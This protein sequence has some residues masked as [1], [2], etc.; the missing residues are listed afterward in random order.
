[1]HGE[2]A[3]KLTLG[4]VYRGVVTSREEDGT[5][6][7]SI[8]SPAQEVRGVLLAVPV[9][10]GL[11]GFNVKCRLTKDTEVELA[12]GEPSFIHSV[13]PRNSSDWVNARNRSLIWGEPSDPKSK[14]K[15]NFSEVTDDLVE[16]EIE[17]SNLFGV[18]LSLLTTLSRMSSGDRAAVECHLIND[19]VR[20]ISAQYRHISGIGDD[21]IFDRGRPTMERRWSSYRHELMNALKDK[22]PLAEL[23]GD[24]VARNTVENERVTALGRHRFIELVGFAGDFIHSFV[25]DP[26]DAAVKLAGAVTQDGAGKSWIH[27]NSD[28]SLIFQSVADIRFERVCRIPVVQRIASHE[29]PEVT[30]KTKYDALNKEYL[31]L[32]KFGRLE[33]KNAFLMAYHIR[34]YARWLSRYHAF[35][36]TLQLDKEY[37]IKSEA[38]SAKPSWTNA[39]QD[40]DDKNGKDIYF[41]AYACFCI[42]R[43]G[44]IVLHD[45]Y[46]SSIVA[47]HGNVQISASRNIDLEAAG[48]VRIVAG[49]NLYLRAR[50]NIEIITHAGGI[51]LY[52]YAWLKAL[53]AKGSL[54]LRSSAR[55]DE[56]PPDPLIQGGPKPEIAGD[57]SGRGKAVLIESTDGELMLRSSS[58]MTIQSDGSSEEIK[59]ALV[60][61]SNSDLILRGKRSTQVSSPR[62]T[63][64]SGGQSLAMAASTLISNAN[65]VFIGSPASGLVYRGGR[66]FAPVIESLVSSA[67]SHTNLS[68]QVGKRDDSVAKPEFNN[69]NANE[70][71]AKAVELVT[72]GP[73]L[74]YESRADGPVWYFCQADQYLYDDFDGMLGSRPETLTQQYLRKDN[75]THVSN[76]E[77]AT[78]NMKFQVTGTRTR[79]EGGFGNQERLMRASDEG[80]DLHKPSTKQPSDNATVTLSW[81]SH[82][83][84]MKVLKGKGE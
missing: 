69:D 17:I 15:D 6:T 52:S 41:D 72:K 40:R 38:Q 54:W 19:M 18:A 70:A 7:V 12:Y 3:A 39:E 30:E 26:P 35:A 11:M 31:K 29:D 4:C 22:E 65:Q 49:N 16:G 83:M 21:L 71:L 67:N 76:N 53:C 60:V 74:E 64:L 1:M 23:N 27:R 32:P 58:G 36:R 80:E 57:D 82:D 24:E 10:G 63:S 81:S 8:G 51:I 44:S 75:P 9:F 28:G 33:S 46:G 47:S 48:D 73:Q 34:Q 55:T 59:D 68:G 50:R 43:D 77:Y 2:T 45:G 25:A 62:T 66:L 20:V 42:L 5:Y 84:T 61:H 78:W 14:G 79:N 56:D 13:L 37:K